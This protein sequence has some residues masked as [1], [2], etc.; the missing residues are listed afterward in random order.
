MTD[1]FQKKTVFIAAVILILSLIPMLEVAVYSRPFA[2]DFGYSAQTHQVWQSTHSVLA[3]L[4]AVGDEVVETYNDWQGSFSAIALFALEPAVFSE[5]IYGLSTLILIAAF[6]AGTFALIRTLI[7][8]D[9]KISFIVFAGVSVLSMQTLPHAMQGFYWWNGASY[10]TLFYSLM[11]IQWALI[12]KREKVILPSILG[13]L[14]GGGNLVS[15]LLNLEVTVLVIAVMFFSYLKS[16]NSMKIEGVWKILIILLFSAL[17][18]VINVAAP[19]N[20]LRAAQSTMR[21]AL[22]AIEVSFE[23][24]YT[25]MNEWMSL[26]VIPLLR[27]SL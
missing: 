12:L 1:S 2:D 7:P 25:Y 4:E 21:P 9:K 18:F 23:N 8:E 5:K 3:L 14:I 16:K 24:A 26:P 20:A 22:E 10:Y 11:L 15:G 6:L 27:I 19:G 17:G 13:F